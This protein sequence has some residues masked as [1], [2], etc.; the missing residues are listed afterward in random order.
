MP[1]EDD[2]VIIE[3]RKGSRE[4]PCEP[5]AILACTEADRQRFCRLATPI[6]TSIRT[7]YNARLQE[8]IHGGRSVTLAGPILGAP[9]AVLVMEKLIAL[10]SRVIIVFGWCGSMQPDVKIGD[11]L[12]PNYARSEEGTSVH[13]PMKSEKF[14]PDADL[15]ARLQG[16]FQQTGVPVR[17]GPI[18]TTDALLR[19]TV[20]KIRAYGKDG[21]LAV[22]MELS[23][24][25][26]VAAYRKVRLVGLLVV[27]DELFTLKWQP[28]FGSTSFKRS[29]NQA[30]QTILDFCSSLPPEFLTGAP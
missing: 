4:E 30:C 22:E 9:Q 27:S 18:W 11:W 12:L 26:H 21:L 16:H 3:S 8:I 17:L 6:A 10:G 19:E 24:L 29:C 23:A 14:S 2:T 13:Y 1:L 20:H 15:L 7:V 5:V 28:G 25:F